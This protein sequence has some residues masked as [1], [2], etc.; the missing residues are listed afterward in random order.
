MPD[1]H[2]SIV[3]LT[4]EEALD[5]AEALLA[6]IAYHVS[7]HD[8]RGWVFVPDALRNQIQTYAKPRMMKGIWPSKPGTATHAL[9]DDE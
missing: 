5:E 4:T 9:G 1:G 7:N 3:V 2:R 8:G 6:E